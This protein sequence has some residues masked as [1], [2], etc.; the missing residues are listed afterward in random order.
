MIVKL[1]S[2][3][4]KSEYDVQFEIWELLASAHDFH[5]V[6]IP[7]ILENVFSWVRPVNIISVSLDGTSLPEVY[8]V[9]DVI[10]LNGG[11][12]GTTYK[13]SPVVKINDTDV[14]T[15]INQYAAM[16]PWGH[17]PDA[18]YNS[19]PD[20]FQSHTDRSLTPLSLGI[21]VLYNIPATSNGFSLR[22]GNFGSGFH[23]FPGSHTTMTFANGSVNTIP[24]YAQVAGDLT[25][26]TDG[27][28]F[29]QKFCVKP[30]PSASA[31]AN[32]VA[33]R[34]ASATLSIV[35]TGSAS[36]SAIGTAS[37]S[38]AA[39]SVTTNNLYTPLAS[40]AP[41]PALPYY[42]APVLIAPDSSIAGYFP[43]A[44]NDLAVITIPTFWPASNYIF[45]N[46]LRTFLATA[47]SSGK[48]KLIIDTRANNG[49][50]VTDGY[51]FFRQLFPSMGAYGAGNMAAWPLADAIG[52]VAS[53]YNDKLLYGLQP[54]SPFSVEEDLTVND[55]AYQS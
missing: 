41:I 34:T 11:L 33:K 15:W 55:T 17:D 43:E 6:Y 9:S 16:E 53:G 5:L 46:K 36:G 27:S 48:T 10:A 2:G 8:D 54:L 18:N 51:S 47:K 45:Q 38:I 32:A 23:R 7:D 25:G 24:S 20:H 22:G 30:A 35:A 42:P 44:F 39:S 26:V 4:Y 28:S 29:F 37:G 21:D 40:A 12:N 13:P 14:E 49:G 31:S 3:G 19:N 50:S 1:R 52:Q